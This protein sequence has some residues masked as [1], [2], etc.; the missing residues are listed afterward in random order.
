MPWEPVDCWQSSSFGLSDL[1]R[2]GR[3]LE[4]LGHYACPQ[5]HSM[6]YS[7]NDYGHVPTQLAKCGYNVGLLNWRFVL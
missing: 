7:Y 3:F 4:N 6:L 2:H 5:S 1:H